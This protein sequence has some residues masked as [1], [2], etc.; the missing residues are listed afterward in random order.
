MERMQEMRPKHTSMDPN[1]KTWGKKKANKGQTC[2]Q[3]LIQTLYY[4]GVYGCR[5]RPLDLDL[6]PTQ[7]QDTRK[8]H[9]IKIFK[10]KNL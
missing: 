5:P 8:I 6:H 1:T 2:K 3:E 10:K 4:T 9:K 7:K